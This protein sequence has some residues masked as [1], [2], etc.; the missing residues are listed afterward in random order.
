MTNKRPTPDH[1]AATNKN[2]KKQRNEKKEK[3]SR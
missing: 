3:Y 1:R 2:E